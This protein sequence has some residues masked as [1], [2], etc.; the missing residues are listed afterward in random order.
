M[1]IIGVFDNADKLAAE[2]EEKNAILQ[3]IKEGRLP[4]F[5]KEVYGGQ[6]D[7]PPA[8]PAEPVAPAPLAAPVIPTIS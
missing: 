6:V 1:A 3:A 8:A 7:A 5:V 4:S 2:L